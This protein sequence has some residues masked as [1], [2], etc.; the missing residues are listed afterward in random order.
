MGIC[1]RNWDL[2]KSSVN[3]FPK[4]ILYCKYCKK[5]MDRVGR[6]RKFVVFFLDVKKQLNL[7]ML[8]LNLRI[9][10]EIDKTENSRVHWS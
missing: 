3:S 10:L 5:S 1:L 9:K 4:N 8:I 7:D 2:A 6:E